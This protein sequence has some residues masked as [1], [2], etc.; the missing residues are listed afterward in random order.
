MFNAA[1]CCWV[2]A[3]LSFCLIVSDRGKILST[4]RPFIV[5]SA[6]P[7]ISYL[8]IRKVSF[9]VRGWVSERRKRVMRYY[10]LSYLWK[11]GN[12]FI[13]GISLA[14]FLVCL[15]RGTSNGMC[16]NYRSSFRRFFYCVKTINY[17]KKTLRCNN[18]FW[19]LKANLFNTVKSNVA[20]TTLNRYS[21]VNKQ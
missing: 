1:A 4:K 7:Q 15:E 20:P 21:F 9:L 3:S 11:V 6:N 10:L 18:D 13:R 12:Y 5:P 2:T 14:K 8:E 17:E 16:W 19:G